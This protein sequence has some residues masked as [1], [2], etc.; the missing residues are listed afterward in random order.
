MA[1]F[2]NAFDS[3]AFDRSDLLSGAAF[4][5]AFDAAFYSGAIT[6]PAPAFDSAFDGWGFY[7]GSGAYWPLPSQVLAGI[8]YGPTGSDYTGTATAGAYPTAADIAA[9]V[10]AYTQ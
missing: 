8:V 6:A 5:S 1:A 10:W 7:V 3:N 9:A 2:S 4:G